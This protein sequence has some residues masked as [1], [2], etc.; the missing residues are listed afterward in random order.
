ML[1]KLV[2]KSGVNREGTRYSTEGG[3]YDCDK[4]RF[5]QGSPEVIG[6]WVKYS[7]ASFVGICRALWNWMT[8][9][10]HNL[11]A[12]GTNL[13]YYINKGGAY[14]DVTPIRYATTLSGAFT[15][16]TGSSTIAVY[17]V[18][19]G[20]LTNDFVTFNGASSLGGTITASLLNQEYQV[21]VVD[22]DT[23][24][25]DVGVNANS[26]DTGDGG[27]VRAVYQINTGADT[28]LP[29]SGWGAG[30]W[31]YGT[32][33]YGAE[34]STSIRLWSQSNYGQSLVFGP[35]GGA[36]YYFDTFSNTSTVGVTISNASPAEIQFPLQT[37]YINEGTTVYLET[38]GAL[39]SPLETGTIYYLRNFDS[40]TYTCNISATTNGALINTVTAG[41]GNQYVS[42][43][44]INITQLAG[45]DVDAPSIQ[46]YIF[47]SDIYRFV[48]A[49]GC[50]DYTTQ[51]QITVSS[52]PPGVVTFPAYTNYIPDG[53]IIFL[54]TTGVLPSPLDSNVPY[55]VRNF[56]TATWT[57]NLSYTTT[58]ALITTTTV[59]SGVHTANVKGVQD[60]LLMRWS[61]QEDF[62]I[63]TPSAANQAGS[64]R[65]SHGSRIIT[66]IQ[67]RQ[68]ILVLTDSAAYSVQYL[69]A[70]FVWNAQIIADNISIVGQN[71]MATA[72]GVVYWMGV[73]KFY[74]YDGRAQTLN[75]NIRAYIFNDFN[76]AQSDQV[77]AGTNEG[78]NEIW[79]FYCSADST[80]VDRYVVYNYAEAIW[81][82]GTMGR[83]AWLDSGI[84]DYPIAA[85]YNNNIVYHENGL[86]D[87]AGLTAQP[88]DAYITTSEFDL[89]QDGHRFMFIKRI[90]PDITFRGSTADNPTVTM[91]IIPLNNS[92]SG[93]T[94]P[95]S[96]GGSANATVTRT[97]TVP[98]EEFTGQVY[99]RIRGRQFAFKVESNQLDTTWQ[100]GSPRCDFQYDGRK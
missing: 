90:L 69:G 24:T 40:T 9:S 34:S 42:P 49:F 15:A 86:N 50:D 17:D 56:N 53:T 44:G 30:P 16:A 12:V 87:Y 46:N 20:C 99:V 66:A 58:G 41:S 43:R 76:N 38:T 4:I 73:D 63:W 98:V 7:T 28:Q 62:L 21:T 55:Y 95:A 5:R 85:T 11:I 57:C 89:D 96:V 70:P 32:W 29:Q 18:G 81:Y 78:F 19:H 13:K 100:L 68:E 36:M 6:G 23:Y 39:P 3:Y 8:L 80:V 77:Y 37:A 71:A 22:E 26:S 72:S 91:S 33:G 51:L 60:P 97:A 75:C 65:L 82:Y 31:G 10:G 64:L 88:I 52:A 47:V 14:Y 1:K 74:A 2:F 54:T 45:A 25:I 79:W 67:T 84:L 83:T 27:A 48:F 35:R 93:Y 92:G 94:A 59:G 61:Q